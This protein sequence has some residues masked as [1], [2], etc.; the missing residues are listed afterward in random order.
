MDSKRKSREIFIDDIISGE[1]VMRTG[2]AALMREG[3]WDG[4]AENGLGSV[5]D[6]KLSESRKSL[7][8]SRSTSG[9]CGGT[10]KGLAF[11]IVSKKVVLRL[12]AAKA[13]T[14]CCG[15]AHVVLQGNTSN[16]STITALENANTER[17]DAT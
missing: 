2:S 15:L 14:V 13:T 12:G 5:F 3:S 4:S 7:E 8:V 6:F 10:K 17:Q 16:S 11:A 9:S 1:R